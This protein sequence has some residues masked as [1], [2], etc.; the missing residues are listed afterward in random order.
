[1]LTRL[2]SSGNNVRHA[3]DDELCDRLRAPSI[4][5]DPLTL[6][7]HKPD[8]L[9]NGES[10]QIWR[11]R[12]PIVDAVRNGTR[13]NV[14]KANQSGN[15]MILKIIRFKS[16]PADY[17]L[18]IYNLVICKLSGSLIETHLMNP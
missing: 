10:G 6:I 2:L 15:K 11:T 18:K 8:V 13:S 14:S 9:L 3:I 4:P 5:A 1:M 16:D 12:V 7:I 17:F